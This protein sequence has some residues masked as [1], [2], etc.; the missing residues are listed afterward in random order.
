MF[1]FVAWSWRKVW[2]IRG[3]MGGMGYLTE[4]IKNESKL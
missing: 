4:V 1:V 2:N 3:L